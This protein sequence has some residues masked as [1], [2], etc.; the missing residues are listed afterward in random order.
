MYRFWLASVG[1]CVLFA[2][3][4][5]ADDKDDAKAILDKAIKA[6]GGEDKLAKP[7]CVTMK[8]K[9]KYYGPG[10]GDDGIEYTMEISTTPSKR[11]IDMEAGGGIFKFS[12]VYNGDKGWRKLND[13]TTDLDK[14]GLEEVKHDLYLDKVTSLVPLKEKDYKLEALAECKVGKKAAVGIKVTH[15]GNR[16]VSLFFDKESGLLLR[17][18][19]SVKDMGEEHNQETVYSEHKEF[20]GRK[21]PTKVVINR[22][23]KLYVE[24]ETSEVKFPEKL[25]DNVFA[26]P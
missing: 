15:K 24:G 5:R 13:D 23:G 18:D 25:E 8:I 2:T 17:L 26:K 19:T 9:G 22:D 7:K 6:Q 14:E 1:V 21:M 4:L 11:R 16:D 3:G 20:D 12:T 10:A